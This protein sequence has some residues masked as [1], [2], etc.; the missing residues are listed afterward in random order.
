[1][2]DLLLEFPSTTAEEIVQSMEECV[3]I[4]HSSVSSFRAYRSMT[5]V[6]LDLTLHGIRPITLN[7]ALGDL[8]FGGGLTESLWKHGE[9]L[10]RHGLISE[11]SSDY[12][13]SHNDSYRVSL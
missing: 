7:E 10:Y 4:P 9:F 12:G 6:L 13:K 2:A 1:M 3:L 8:W 5:V 11:V